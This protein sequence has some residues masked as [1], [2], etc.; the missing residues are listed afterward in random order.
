MSLAERVVKRLE[1]EAA[2]DQTL[3]MLLMMF[4][5]NIR[6]LDDSTLRSLIERVKVE[7]DEFLNGQ[8]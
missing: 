7:C 1:K 8:T 3:S 6:S 4:G 5:G 2:G